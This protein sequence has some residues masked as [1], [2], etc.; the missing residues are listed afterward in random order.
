[1][2]AGYRRIAP[3]LFRTLTT[4]VIHPLVA[5]T[6]QPIRAL[7]MILSVCNR[8]AATTPIEVQQTLST[9]RSGWNVKDMIQICSFNK[10]SFSNQVVPNVIQIP[11]DTK[12]AYPTCN[13][14]DWANYADTYTNQMMRVPS[15]KYNTR[16]YVLP[17]ESGCGFGGLGM[18][19][20]CGN[21]CRVWVN[22]KISNQVSVYFHELGHNLGLGH[23]SYMSDQYGDFTDAMGYCCNLRCFA[24]PNT[25]RLNWSIP[26]FRHDIPFTKPQTYTLLPNTYILLKDKT[27]Q[28]S[29]FVQLRVPKFLKYDKD[30]TLAVYVYTMS[31]VPYAQSNYVAALTQ[32]GNSWYSS[33]S[34]YSIELMSISGKSATVT[35]R[36]TNLLAATDAFEETHIPV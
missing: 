17:P 20:P 3:W 35:I 36:P 6:A 31:F 10:S 19:G 24:A 12:N 11:C 21:D 22:G 34:A 13:V 18:I 4:L 1:M 33:T 32:K 27:R 16:I 23:A 30:I 5:T 15:Q 2:T 9:S 8:Y 7:T 28:E 25:Y 14:Y 26:L 29:T